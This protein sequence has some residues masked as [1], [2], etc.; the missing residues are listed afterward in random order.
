MSTFH[1]LF[2]VG[3][4]LG[5]GVAGLALRWDVAASGHM[6]GV[7]LGLAALTVLGMPH[8]LPDTAEQQPAGPAI[9]LPA[10]PLLGLGVLAFSCLVAEGAMADWS[11]VYLRDRLGGDPGFA[12][13]GYAAFSLAMAAGRFGGDAL[14]ARLRA[15]PLVRISGVLAATGLGA[16]LVVAQP[17]V[18][19]AGFACIGLGLANI[20]PVLF[21]AAARTSGTTP[22]SGIAA[23]ASVGYFGFLVGPPLIGFVSQLTSLTGGLGLVVLLM[24]LIALLARRAAW[25][26]LAAA[27]PEQR[28]G[29][30]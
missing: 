21:T 6:A 16:A 2:S 12:A 27:A 9:A 24:A 30:R 29:S 17:M 4:L 10:G 8:L 19:L 28:A 18:T 20:V 14:R 25:A 23:V 1:A 11:A 7:A 5:A 15:V 26:D 22:G 3:G 13:A